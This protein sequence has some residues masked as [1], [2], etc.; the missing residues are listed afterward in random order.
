[1]TD[2]L[3]NTPYLRRIRHEGHEEGL[4]VGKEL[5]L[6]EGLREAVLEAITVRFN[7]PIVEYRQVSRQLTQLTRREQLQNLLTTALQ[8][9]TMAEFTAQLQEVV[10]EGDKGHGI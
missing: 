6:L 2:E 4:A 1:M 5:G 9:G 3:L 8:A 10:G 7:P